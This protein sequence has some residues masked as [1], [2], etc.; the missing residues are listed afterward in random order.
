MFLKQKRSA[1]EMAQRLKEALQDDLIA[2]VLYG[3]QAGGDATRR[4]SDV[5]LLVFA[6]TLDAVRLKKAAS[7]VR[8]WTL[9][10]QP[11]PLFFTPERWKASLDVFPVEAL[12][13]RD[14]HR[15][16]VGDVG[17]L[18]NQEIPMAFFRWE[19]E[20]ELKSKLL[21]LREGFLAAGGIKKEVEK[22]LLNA[23]STFLVL[24]RNALRLWEP[25]EKPPTLKIEACR[26]LSLH[27]GF[28]ME[29]VEVLWRW[30]EGGKKKEDPLL[31]F[32]AFL[33]IVEK[34]VDAVDGW[35]VGE[36][37]KEGKR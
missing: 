11:P 28:S 12:D 21:Y 19:L 37:K 5:N 31:V 18:L 7:L 30:K 32:E 15:I 9:A 2:V 23:F 27:L 4:F 13:I 17:D 10:G 14:N 8:G 20:R 25:E 33:L 22:V 3:S 36:T 1:Q 35:K 29:A 34:V 6:R 16:L 26:K 24:F